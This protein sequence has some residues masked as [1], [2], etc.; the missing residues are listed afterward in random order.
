[1]AGKEEIEMNKGN[2]IICSTIAIVITCLVS[3]PKFVQEFEFGQASL[4]RLL[5]GQESVNAELELTSIQRKKIEK[6]RERMETINS[7]YVKNAI[8]L[9]RTDPKAT[10][11]LK[12]NLQKEMAVEGNLLLEHLLPHQKKRLGQLFRRFWI[13]NTERQI[14]HIL[15]SKTLRELRLTSNQTTKIKKRSERHST[16]VSTLVEKYKEELRKLSD[17]QNAEMLQLLDDDQKR[18]YDEILGPS[19]S[20]R[21]SF[22]PS[23]RTRITDE[24]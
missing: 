21:E 23:I 4:L 18:K 14:D 1:M 2:N 5:I 6:I 20:F 24:R 22:T 17:K 13:Y 3:T 9:M 15:L 16:E 7:D 11:P 8:E 19:F 12:A 10:G